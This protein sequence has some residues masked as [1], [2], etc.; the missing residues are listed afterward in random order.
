MNP[1]PRDRDEESPGR[2][3]PDAVYGS[4][5]QE[6][7][8]ARSEIDRVLK[9]RFEKK[10][11]VLFTDVHRRGRLLRGPWRRRRR[12]MLSAPTTCC[13]PVVEA[14]GGRVVKTVGAAIMAFFERSQEAVEAAI[15]MQLKMVEVNS[16]ISSADDRVHIRIGISS[17]PA[18]V[19]AS[20]LYGDTVNVAARVQAQAVRDQIL[21]SAAV[22]GR[23]RPLGG[24][25]PVGERLAQGERRAHPLF[26]VA[27]R[28]VTRRQI[29]SEKPKV[30]DRYRV[31]SPRNR[32]DG[33]GVEG[34]GSA[35]PAPVL[36]KVLHPPSRP[37][38]SG[39]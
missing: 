34:A 17:G 12:A 37:D 18:F 33:G 13:F 5:V 7:L 36:I 1:D 27:W 21:V 26:E 29:T 32:R 19:E 31:D 38:A 9:E 22:R 16:R 25:L 11:T 35:A 15:Q 28:D 10:V 6:L 23:A 4:N 3:T 14:T 8:R 2:T 24:L 30:S 39:S 20:D